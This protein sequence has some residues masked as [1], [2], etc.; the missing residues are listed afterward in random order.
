MIYIFGFKKI[1]IN[2]VLYIGILL[3]KQK[4]QV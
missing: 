4:L 2:M 1:V 3:V